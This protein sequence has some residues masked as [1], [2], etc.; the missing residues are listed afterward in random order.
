MDFTKSQQDTLV[1][2]L[3]AYR[4]S[5]KRA[6]DAGVAMNDALTKLKTASGITGNDRVQIESEVV[7]ILGGFYLEAVDKGLLTAD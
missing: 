2:A 1:A 7:N 5:V 3:K 4:I 6:N